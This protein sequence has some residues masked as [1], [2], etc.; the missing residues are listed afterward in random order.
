MRAALCI[1]WI[2]LE[3]VGKVAEG[4]KESNGS[5][6]FTPHVTFL[7]KSPPRVRPIT[8]NVRTFAVFSLS[9]VGGGNEDSRVAALECLHERYS[10]LRLLLCL[11]ERTPAR[12]PV[13]LLSPTSRPYKAS[14]LPAPG[15]RLPP[16]EI[17]RM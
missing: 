8:I 15:P 11:A 6:V 3:G 14:S 16:R 12:A 2:W 1:P 9:C 13:R 10:Q 5:G 7:Y 17:S 4:N